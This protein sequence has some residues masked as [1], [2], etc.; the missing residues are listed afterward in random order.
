[1]PTSNHEKWELKDKIIVELHA[2]V[3]V[4]L[5]NTYGFST[6]EVQEQMRK[7]L[8]IKRFWKTK[9]CGFSLHKPS[10]QP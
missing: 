8:Q 1:M 9:R 4:T 2:S 7:I 6:I 5:A 3:V 10:T